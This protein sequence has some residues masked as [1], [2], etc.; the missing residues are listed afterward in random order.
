M[1]SRG[2]YGALCAAPSKHEQVAYIGTG[3]FE[4]RQFVCNPSDL[5][6][7]DL[8]HFLMIGWIATRIPGLDIRFQTT[9]TM[10]ESGHTRDSPWPGETRV[11]RERLKRRPTG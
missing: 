5:S 8:H 10:L 1:L 9:D 7:A 6:S 2:E 11:A 4:R 3:N